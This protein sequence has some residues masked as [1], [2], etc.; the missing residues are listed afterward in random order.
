MPRAQVDIV[1]TLRDRPDLF[2]QVTVLRAEP[3]G[4][5]LPW[6]CGVATVRTA[7]LHEAIK[8]AFDPVGILNAGRGPV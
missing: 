7:A 2:K 1:R 4:S 8:R 5:R 6:T 3:A